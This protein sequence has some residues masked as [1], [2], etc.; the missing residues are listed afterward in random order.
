M[1]AFGDQLFEKY[2]TSLHQIFRIG[3][4]MGAELQMIDQ[5]LVL[6]TLNVTG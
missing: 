5:I 2:L 4:N 3:R 6:H 1:I